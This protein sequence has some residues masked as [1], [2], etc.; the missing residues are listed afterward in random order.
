[1]SK[2]NIVKPTPNLIKE[3]KKRAK[4]AKQQ[5]EKPKTVESEVAEI[6]AATNQ[7]PQETTIEQTQETTPETSLVLARKKSKK[8]EGLNKLSSSG[9]IYEMPASTLEQNK[10]EML[11]KL[12]NKKKY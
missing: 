11:Q 7:S 8:S 12:Q 1:M 10:K 2:E 9:K 6:L 5:K 4:R 3:D